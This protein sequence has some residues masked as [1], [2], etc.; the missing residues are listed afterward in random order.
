MDREVFQIWLS[1]IDALTDVQR[2]DVADALAGRVIGGA[3]RAA[4]EVLRWGRSV[5]SALCNAWRGE[6][7]YGAWVEAVS[8]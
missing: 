7:R 8:V 2:L 4:I 5:L 3:S 6:A 1:E